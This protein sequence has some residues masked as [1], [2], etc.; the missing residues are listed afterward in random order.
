MLPDHGPR[1]FR[2]NELSAPPRVLAHETAKTEEAKMNKLTSRTAGLVLAVT[3]S[4]AIL[5]PLGL[6]HAAPAS[7]ASTTTK[8]IAVSTLGQDFRTAL[9][10]IRGPSHGG[11]PAATVKVAV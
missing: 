6:A 10:A 1:A 7:T 3:A 5:L 8:Q 9:T 11:A 4:F 2:P